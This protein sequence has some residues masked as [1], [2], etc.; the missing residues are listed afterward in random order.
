MKQKIKI[1]IEEI[2]TTATELV[3]KSRFDTNYDVLEK[4]HK[5]G[6]ITDQEYIISIYL[7][8]KSCGQIYIA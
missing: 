3:G 1:S 5:A 7:L 6:L 8:D 2:L 4:A